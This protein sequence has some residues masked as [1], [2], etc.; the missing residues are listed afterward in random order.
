MLPTWL[1][2]L[3]EGVIDL[4]IGH[5]VNPLPR[6][7]SILTS[8]TCRQSFRK[9]LSFLPLTPLILPFYFALYSPLSRIS[10]SLPPSY[11]ELNVI[12]FSSWILRHLKENSQYSVD[13]SENTDSIPGG[14][15]S[16]RRSWPS[17]QHCRSYRQVD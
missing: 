3:C 13:V 14:E 6:D 15:L 7:F 12:S 1:S 2:W 9:E 17:A 10:L 8:L 11:L 5:E 16:Q 4:C